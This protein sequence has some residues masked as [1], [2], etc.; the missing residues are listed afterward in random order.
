MDEYIR[1]RTAEGIEE[2]FS[3]SHRQRSALSGA[4]TPREQVH[5]L[6]RAIWQPGE[7]EEPWDAASETL[8]RAGYNSG[9]FG[10]K[11]N[12]PTME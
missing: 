2:E 5:R 1:N 11:E 3:E 12:P 9:E 7:H 6:A 8:K 10:P 4:H